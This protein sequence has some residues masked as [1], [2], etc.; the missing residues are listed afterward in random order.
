MALK[1]SLVESA[2]AVAEPPAAPVVPPAPVVLV[3]V[4]PDQL[5]S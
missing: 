4:A 5:L 3:L 1:S 2:L